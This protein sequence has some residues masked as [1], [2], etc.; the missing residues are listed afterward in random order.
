MKHLIAILFV[1]CGLATAQVNPPV[2]WSTSR[3]AP[4]GNCP[5]GRGVETIPGGVLYTCQNGTWTQISGGG[6]SSIAPFTTDGTNV[7]LPSGN[8]SVGPTLPAGWYNIA[9]WGDS[10]TAGTG[11]TPYPSQLQTLNG[12]ASYNG[13]F[14]GDTSTQIATRFLAD[15]THRSWQTIIWAGRNNYSSPTTV[16]ADIASIVAAL[17]TPKNFLVLSVLNGDYALEYSGQSNY[18]VIIALN[19][20]LA[21]AYP[22]NYLDVRAAIVA[23]YSVG[24]AQDVIDHG[25]DVPPSSL[26][27]L[28]DFVGTLNGAIA[29]TVTCSINLTNVTGTVGVGVTLN[30]DTEK[31]YVSAAT[32]GNVTG[33]TRGYAGTT[34]ATHLTGAAYAGLDGTHLNAAGYLIVAQQINAWLLAHAANYVP[35]TADIANFFATPPPTGT[36]IPVN[37]TTNIGSGSQPYAFFYG[38][39]V[40]LANGKCITIAGDGLGFQF[41]GKL[42]ASTDNTYDIG[43]SA[44]TYRFRHMYLAGNATIGGYAT[45][46]GWL[47]ANGTVVLGSLAGC[48][49]GQKAPLYINENKYMVQGTCQ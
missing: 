34:A 31:I 48:T 25:H 12:R 17:P 2:T 4:T 44:S 26:R 16:L 1:A 49:T 10:L 5:Q 23:S 3:T 24:N 14:G 21:S 42:I 18:N 22:N 45:I 37:S 11:G 43:Q 20:A 32:A 27:S 8:L 7:S 36:L 39:S 38:S 40:C 29:D 41:P 28:L 6:G 46:T 15:S 33:C 47:T 30:V 13:G 19:A 35:G 9:A